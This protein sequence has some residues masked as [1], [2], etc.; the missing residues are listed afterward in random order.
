[1]TG[2]Y[3]TVKENCPS[4]ICKNNFWL[5]KDFPPEWERVESFWLCTQISIMQCI[6]LKTASNFC[7]DQNSCADEA[8]YR[9]E[10]WLGLTWKSLDTGLFRNLA[11]FMWANVANVDLIFLHSLLVFRDQMENLKLLHAPPVICLF[12]PFPV[13]LSC[14]WCCHLH[15]QLPHCLGLPY[16]YHLLVLSWYLHQ[17]APHLLSLHK[18]CLFVC[19]YSEIKWK[20]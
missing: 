2:V 1:M 18:V 5:W 20:I 10:N 7:N 8:F 11:E 3:F 17:P 12:D 15:C 16:R 4:I 9:I 6:V 19:W 13:S 14:L